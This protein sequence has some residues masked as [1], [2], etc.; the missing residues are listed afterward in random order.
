[1]RKKDIGVFFFVAGI[2]FFVLQI[3]GISLSILDG[4]SDPEAVFSVGTEITFKSFVSDTWAGILGTCTAI[5]VFIRR[6]AKSP[7]PLLDIVVGMLWVIQLLGMYNKVMSSVPIG[8]F[9]M[10]YILGVL[11]IVCMVVV[12]LYDTHL[13][14]KREPGDK[15]D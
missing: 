6:A 3:L 5:V 1:M 2:V 12:C 8:S 13:L 15:N 9:V 4:G 14:K 11:G 7:E 10:D